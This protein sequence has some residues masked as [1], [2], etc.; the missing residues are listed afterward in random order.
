MG[1]SNDVS[2]AGK[3]QT[4]EVRGVALVKS[5]HAG[6]GEKAPAQIMTLVFKGDGGK[7]LKEWPAR[8]W[9]DPRGIGASLS[10][11]SLVLAEGTIVRHN[12]EPQLRIT[13]LTP[14]KA[15]E[16][17]IQAYIP[18]SSLP[19]GQAMDRIDAFMESLSEPHLKSFG[20]ELL[21]DPEIRSLF[22]K[23]PAAKRNHHAVVG[24]L[25]E[26]TLE[27]MEMGDRIAPI[28]HLNRDLLLL[29]LLLHDLGKC[30]EISSRPGFAYTDDGRLLGHMFLGCDAIRRVAGR[31]PDFPEIFLKLLQH[32]ILSH[33][34]EMSFGSPVLPATPEA[35]A[36]HMLDNLSG[37]V[38]AMR[39]AKGADG[40][41]WGYERNRGAQIW[42][43]G[44]DPVALAKL[45]GAGDRSP[46]QG[47]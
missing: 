4:K 17:E 32:F 40:D 33:H 5:R 42:H 24:G 14:L 2:T 18:Q 20:L 36:V 7:G 12:Q 9:E 27:I 13:R 39:A 22:E 11:G 26:H 43:R 34:G 28:L 21:A 37:Q 10:V 35:M 3:S 44:S 19:S 29:G 6:S 25:L 47:S 38:Y 16:E 8:L 30:W 31:I 41:D 15:S 1:T 45:S 46:G 23:A